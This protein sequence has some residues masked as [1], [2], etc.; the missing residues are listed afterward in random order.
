MLTK[1]TQKENLRCDPPPITL[2][3]SVRSPTVLLLTCLADRMSWEYISTATVRGYSVTAGVE[4]ED[5]LYL[6]RSIPSVPERRTH[7]V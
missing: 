6:M 7:E 5:M 3:S 1:R 2:A 4:I